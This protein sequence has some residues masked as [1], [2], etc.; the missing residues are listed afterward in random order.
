MFLKGIFIFVLMLGLIVETA[1]LT[2]RENVTHFNDTQTTRPVFKC[3]TMDFPFV[4][5]IAESFRKKFEIKC[6]GTLISSYWVMT[7]AACILNT[8][9]LT[10]FAG[11]SSPQGPLVRIAA[12]KFN[13]PRFIPNTYENDIGVIMLASPM[14]LSEYIDFAR[15]P[16]RQLS[17]EYERD[18]CNSTL[19]MGWSYTR[20]RKS[21]S[22]LPK[23]IN[24]QCS[25]F[26][27]LPYEQCIGQVKNI[28]PTQMCSIITN[29]EDVC[30]GDS[31]G[32]LLC[33]A[34]VMGVVN[35]GISCGYGKYSAVYTR[36]DT[37]I[38]YITNIMS[39]H[40]FSSR[41]LLANSAA[42]ISIVLNSVIFMFM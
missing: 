24:L 11:F 14:P 12:R 13:H 40:S 41:L 37:H 20:S 25:T 17:V 22:D 4:V 34:I 1:H 32:P 42:I 2:T 18:I 31:G 10:V 7:T 29:E 35:S 23:L 36:L 30:Q 9:R 26:R 38:N 28:N 27:V 19:L 33:G 16:L 39:I 3:S 5:C 8:R 21:K 15:L 6:A